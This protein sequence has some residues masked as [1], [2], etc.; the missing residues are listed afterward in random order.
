MAQGSSYTVSVTMQNT[1]N[2]TWKASSGYRL[3]SQNP[4]GNTTWGVAQ[5]VLPN[6]VAPGSSV[7][8]NFN[9]TSPTARGT[10]NFQWRLRS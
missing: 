5:A 8:I 7:T 4:V 1:G 9:V 2:T 3:V 6:D 10:Y